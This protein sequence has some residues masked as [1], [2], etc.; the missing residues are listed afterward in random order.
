[1][2]SLTTDD[3]RTFSGTAP[4]FPLDSVSLLPHVV[5]PL[6]IFEPRYRAMTAAALD[7]DRLLAMAVIQPGWAIHHLEKDVPVCETVCLG[8]ITVNQE[9]ED[10]RFVLVVRGLTRARVISELETDN[11]FRVARLELL[12]DAYPAESSIHREH[13]RDEL[14]ALF[15]R[16]HP[17][18]SETPAFAQLLQDEL[19]LGEL[20]DVISFAARLSNAAALEVLEET[21]V[22]A[23]S[24]IVLR[25]LK[26]ALR[27]Q[28]ST[29]EDSFPPAFSRN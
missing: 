27:H 10:G 22:D 12:P 7:S 26:R 19:Q 29:C 17:S 11:A 3:L 5:Q 14:I 16:L 23:R 25:E 24:D 18:L 28:H 2:N 20:C 9:L 21:N 6:H 4:L 13:R 8:R 1:M 15:N